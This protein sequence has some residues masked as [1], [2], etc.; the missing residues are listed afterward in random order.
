MS[1][2]N[3]QGPDILENIII[4]GSSQEPSAPSI[5]LPIT[6]GD[7]TYEGDSV[8]VA[9]D[10]L[11]SLTADL[12]AQLD[13][14][15]YVTPVVNTF[16]L[17]SSLFELGSTI[18]TLTFAWTINK[19]IVSQSITGG[20]ISETPSIGVRNI[21]V[22][23]LSITT[24]T[25]FTITVNDGT[26]NATK[27]VSASFANKIYYGARS[28]PLV[29]DP[30]FA[31]LLTG[32]VRTSRARTFTVNALALDYVWFLL[33]VDYGTPV[34]TVGGFEGGFSLQGTFEDTLP[35]HTIEDPH[36]ETYNIYRS[37]LPNLG[38]TT[39]VVS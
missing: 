24:P 21:T 28:Q 13:A 20:P 37:N 15:L 38:S 8:T 5:E 22:S 1:I 17:S 33:P 26:N 11:Y 19:S 6:S 3:D 39:I 32:V 16:S 36:T 7:V 31:N 18:T 27:T 35:D 2:I 34:F 25:T 30:D 29:V 9:L 12:Q 4:S 10:D 14:A 23:G